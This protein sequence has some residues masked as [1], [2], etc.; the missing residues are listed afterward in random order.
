[1]KILN[2]IPLLIWSLGFIAMISIEEFQYKKN[3]I[4]ILEESSKG[5]A[6]AYIIGVIAW[7]VIG[8]GC[9]Q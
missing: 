9:S 7:F 8:M 1:M 3:K 4:P 6:M 2:F 5:A